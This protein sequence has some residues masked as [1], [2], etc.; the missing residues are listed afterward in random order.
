[1]NQPFAISTLC[2]AV[3]LLCVVGTSSTA[4]EPEFNRD[5]RVILSDRCFTCHGPDAGSR[6]ADLRLDDAAAALES[7]VLGE[8]S[9][10]SELWARIMSEDD[11]YRMPPPGSNRLP[12]SEVEKE[13][14]SKWIDNGAQYELHWSLNAVEDVK[15]PDVTDEAWCNNPIDRFVRAK[16]EAKQLTPAKS[17]DRTTLARRLYFDLLGLPP[18]P[19]QVAAFRDDKRPDA[20]PRLVEQLLASPRFGERMAVYWLDLVRFANSVGYHGDQEHAIDP[21]RSYVITAFN[22]NLPFDQFTREQLAGDLLEDPTVDQMI[23]TGYNRLLQTSHE[24]GVQQKEYLTKYAADRVRNLSSVW[25][26]ATMGCAECHDHKFDPYSQR[27]FYRLA[28]FFADVDDS[29]TFG[30]SNAVVTERQPELKVLS[31]IQ[32]KQIRQ[33]K[34]EIERLTS[35]A[36]G[37]DPRIVQLKERLAAIQQTSMRTMVTKSVEPRV[38]RVLDRGD[39][40]DTSGEVVEPGVPGVLPPLSDTGG[41]ATRL[42]LVEWLMDPQHPQASRVFV[43]RLWYLMF[44]VGIT[45]D[46]EDIGSQGELPTHPLLLDWLAQEFVQSGWNMKQMVRLIVLSNTYQQSSVVSD[47]QRSA[48]PENRRF[49]RAER[50]RLPAEFVRDALLSVSGLLVLEQSTQASRPRQPVGYYAHL[51]F[52]TRKYEAG[53]GANQYL[54]GV[55]VHWQRQFLH[56]MLKAFDAP[57]REECVA[58]RTESNTPQAALT[59]LNDPSLVEAAVALGR[60]AL[61]TPSSS[62][63]QRLD[64][65]WQQVVTRPLE[66]DELAILRQSLDQNRKQYSDQIDSARAFIADVEFT[67]DPA[68]LAAWAAVGRAMLNVSEAI[69]RN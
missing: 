2:V 47:E 30:G 3:L 22:N 25:M 17:A 52:P 15:V 65:M 24:G 10:E 68:E 26:G 11:D 41:R 38:T 5:I 18:T 19:E 54:R 33:L 63:D 4:S 28:A 13:L 44:G 21:Y 67:G 45:R 39:W 8:S 12:L 9:E 6:E 7:G 53:A 1:M 55:Y 31:P 59:L 57:S 37:D 42:D 49:T 46:L 48:D 29:Q 69:T 40:M 56:P 35:L 20:Y 66:A 61:L 27:D 62:D 32:R 14:I 64:W 23:A 58:K 60:R 43:N 34:S 51:N 50:Y 16:Q 36:D